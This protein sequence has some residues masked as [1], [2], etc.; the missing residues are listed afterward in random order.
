MNQN[1]TTTPRR[2]APRK[3][4]TVL[5]SRGTRLV[6][7]ISAHA[8]AAQVAIAMPLHNQAGTLR[9]ALLSAL[10][11]R[12]TCGHCVII[13][14]D[15]QSTD[16]WQQTVQDLLV[17]PAIV[18]LESHCGTAA[19]ARNAI[20]DFVDSALPEVQW[21]A[22]LDP[23]D[24]LCS[25]KSVDALRVAGD[26]NNASYSVG[27]NYLTLNGVTVAPDNIADPS[28]LLNCEKLTRFIDDFCHGRA[29]NELPSCNL[30]LRTRTGVRY[31]LLKS[32]ED[33]WLV[34]QLLM[35]KPEQAAVTPL[36]VY[37]SYALNG[38][39]TTDN[40]STG[41]HRTARESLDRA[42]KVWKHAISL[43]A[44]V[45]G[46]G[47]EGCVLKQGE[48]VI[49]LFYPD[50]IS[51][52]ELSRLREI[53]QQVNQRM[54]AFEWSQDAT[55]LKMCRYL[56]RPLTQLA[57][58]IPESEIQ[59]FLLDFA[60]AGFVACNIKRDNLRMDDGRLVYID[61]GRDIRTYTP[62]LLLDTAARLYGA[63]VLEMPDGDLSRRPSY[64]NQ[65]ESLALLP[66]FEN[67]Y[68]NLIAKLHPLTSMNC[69]MPQ[70][71]SPAV[72]VTLLIK[73]C[74]QDHASLL[75]QAKHIV[76]QLS[77]PRAFY[78][79]VLVIDPHVGSY[80]RQFSQGDLRV[81]KKNAAM[82]HESGVIDEFLIA[83]SDE[84]IVQGVL[85]RWFGIP[86]IGSTHTRNG[87]P[88]F[89]QLWAFE[90]IETRYVLQA[91]VDVLIGRKDGA[92]DYLS[93]MLTAI[94]EEQTWCVGFNIPQKKSGFA[95]YQSRPEGF[96]PEIRL[97]L[98]DLQKVRAQL[99]LMNREVNGTL[100]DM[101][102]R[103]MEKA[104]LNNKMQSVRGGDDRSFFIHPPNEVKSQA[105]FEVLRDIIGQGFYPEAQAGKWDLE[106]HSDWAYPKRSERLVFLLKGRNTPRD[107]LSRCLSSLKAQVDQ[108]F[109]VILIDDASDAPRSW[110][111]VDLLGELRSRTTLVRRETRRGYI[112]NFLLASQICEFDST[113]IAVLDQDDSLMTVNVVSALNDAVKEGGDLINGLMFRPNKPTRLYLVDYDRVREKGGGNTWSHLRAFKKSL[114]DEVPIDQFKVDGD[115]IDDVS[116]YATMLPMA[117][118]AKAPVQ[119]T[120]QFYVWHDR[121]EYSMQRKFIQN[122]LIAEL[123]ARPPL[124]HPSDGT[125]KTPKTTI[126]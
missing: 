94:H 112:P 22:R 58:R 43:D 113:L 109:G 39:T 118:L 6:N 14:L 33:H 120:D 26:T 90:Q 15:D 89:S 73:A 84:E 71:L 8:F 37:C 53:S 56:W 121:P 104:Q 115:W 92:H 18:V 31:P 111:V 114:F 29:M 101:W 30:L 96:V 41:V 85:A 21:V 102:H 117:E 86:K 126:D 3:L 57:S 78:K 79:V 44:Q 67:F 66:G 12:L 16:E 64:E 83:P 69:A 45:L 100:L 20:L 65:H 13:L 23:D 2:Y 82:L 54:P 7:D 59:A 27:S 46:S 1:L 74:P 51:A 72:E 93:E 17:S 60:N 35:F 95:P 88:L 77:R 125:I 32:A 61:I 110:S 76:A 116:D 25:D 34:A 80:L 10:A 48:H 81:L 124:M 49:K 40:H 42:A 70:A 5:C 107:K 55:G 87:A 97:G 103:S 106:L 63:C 9:R 98:L 123:L 68:R 105:N 99:P 62:S 108:D 122:R 47:M 19:H 50:A 4:N 11:Q 28:V 36:P 119:L 38:A 91:D 52:E 24:V 75:Q